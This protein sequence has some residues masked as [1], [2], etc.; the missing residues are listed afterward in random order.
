MSHPRLLALT[1]SLSL[2]HV[3][4]CAHQHENLPTYRWTDDHTALRIL[5]ERSRSVRTVSASGFLTLTRPDGQSVRLEG[6]LVMSL[7]DRSVRLQA[8]K[9]NQKV[10]DLT[11]TPRGLW[12]ELPQDESRRQRV[13]PARM[14]AAQFAHA[15]SLFNGEVFEKARVADAGG[16]RFEV[17]K[18]LD[19]GQTLIAVIDRATL[20][21]REYQLTD[22]AGVVR[23][24]LT[25]DRYIMQPAGIPWSSHMVARS[26]SG[27][28][29]MDLREI[30]L[31]G[32]LPPTAFV[33][34]RGAEQMP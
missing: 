34:A 6:P 10:L 16:P 17:R 12:I 29:D 26:D 9:F 31:N 19:Q 8:W 15:L 22:P 11:S 2:L 25:A 20:T 13:L 27:R 24:T 23:F 7:P 1:L 14:S 18:S 21:V 4:G 32:E 3:V 30:E 33:P 28:I 5:A